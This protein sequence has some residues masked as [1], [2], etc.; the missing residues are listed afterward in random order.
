MN[1]L[2]HG[3]LHQVHI[4]YHLGGERISDM[5]MKFSILQIIWKKTNKDLEVVKAVPTI[6]AEVVIEYLEEREGLPRV[7][8]LEAEHGV[9]VHGK[10]GP[11]QLAVLY[12]QVAEPGKCLEI[13]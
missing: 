13:K 5:L 8:V 7:G 4:S 2:T 1:G 11:E 12:Q 6:S 3:G 10:Q 9:H